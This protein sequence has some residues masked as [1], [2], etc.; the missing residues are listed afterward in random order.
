M[1]YNAIVRYKLLYKNGWH[2]HKNDTQSY[3]EVLRKGTWWVWLQSKGHWFSEFRMALERSAVKRRVSVQE[4]CHCPHSQGLQFFVHT[5]KKPGRSLGMRLI[6][7]YL[8]E[9]VHHKSYGVTVKCTHRTHEY[10]HPF[11]LQQPLL[12]TSTHTKIGTPH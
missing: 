5:H 3:S 11:W 4:I 6:G 1:E 7:R 2:S 12:F 10:R 9:I 8:V